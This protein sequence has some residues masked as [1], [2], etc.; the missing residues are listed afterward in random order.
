MRLKNRFEM[1]Q[2]NADVSASAEKLKNATDDY[3]VNIDS[4]FEYR[5]IDFLTVFTAVSQIVV[6]RSCGSDVKF[7]DQSRRG[8]GYKIV[9]QCEKCPITVIPATPIIRKFAYEINRRIIFA[10]RLIGVGYNG[11]AKF[12]AFM[13]LPRPVFHSF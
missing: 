12:C 4:T 7:S 10:M 1:E 13:D 9:A 11:L 3:K 5:L 2:E 6:C 8:L